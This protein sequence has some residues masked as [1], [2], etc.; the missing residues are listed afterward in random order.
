LGAKRTWVEE[1]FIVW[2]VGEMSEGTSFSVTL[3]YDDNKATVGNGAMNAFVAG[4]PEMVDEIYKIAMASGGS[5]EGE[6]GYRG[7]PASGF[8]AG[9]F[10][11][12]EGNKLNAFCIAPKTA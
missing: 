10:R 5:D 11:D 6:P 4:S 2:S 7:D 1:K 8:Y 12:P 3:P 9:Y